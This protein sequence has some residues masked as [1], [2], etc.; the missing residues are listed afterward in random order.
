MLFQA[1]ELCLKICESSSQPSGNTALQV[2]VNPGETTSATA[3]G[4]AVIQKNLGVF[5]PWWFHSADLF[6]SSI[7]DR[8]VGWLGPAS[9]LATP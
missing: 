7:H 5:V 8:F 1:T 3:L 9:P 4:S 6:H 2:Q